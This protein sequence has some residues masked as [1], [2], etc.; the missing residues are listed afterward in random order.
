[1]QLFLGLLAVLLSG[2]TRA[3]RTI[4]V[5]TG[6][7]VTLSC[8][9]T[10]Y[11]WPLWDGPRIPRMNED[12]LVTYS[13][14]FFINPNLP[15]AHKLK[16]TENISTGKYDLQISNASLNEEG[17]YRC[18]DLT[19]WKLPKENYVQLKIKVP[20]RNISINDA[21]TGVLHGTEN[22]F[23]VLRCSVNSGVPKETIMWFNNSLLLGIGGPGTFELN[24]IPQKY[25]HGRFYTCII[26]SSALINF[27][28]QTVKLDIKYK[29]YVTVRK[30]KDY[31]RI[32][33]A[34]NLSVSCLVDSNPVITRIFWERNSTV[35]HVSTGKSTLSL[36]L[37]NV[38]RVDSG[39]YVCRAANA[40]GESYDSIE[41]IVQYPP[42]IE[43]KIDMDK[44]VL[45]CNPNG[46]PQ[47]YTFYPWIHQSEF[48]DIIRCLKNT[49]TINLQ[50]SDDTLN[51]YQ[52]NGIYIC[53]AGNGVANTNATEIQSGQ[54]FVRQN[55][56]PVFVSQNEHRQYG[57]PG[58]K[59]D[60]SVF[61]YSYPKFNNLK[62]TTRGLFSIE[63]NYIDIENATVIDRFHSND[64]RM[65]GFKITLQGFIIEANDF[66]SYKFWI[67]NSVGN[68]NFTVDLIDAE[69]QSGRPL[70]IYWQIA[71]SFIGVLLLGIACTIFRGF[72]HKQ[73]RKHARRQVHQEV[74]Y[75][76][77]E[78]ADNNPASQTQRNNHPVDTDSVIVQEP[79][80]RNSASENPGE[81]YNSE[82]N[83]SRSVSVARELHDYENSYQPLDLDNSE[84]HLYDETQVL[85]SNDIVSTESTYVN[86][87]L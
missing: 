80:S 36:N 3:N 84:K 48:G 41:I 76:E 69:K 22:H 9:V 29:P 82:E 85:C 8:N 73:R 70:N 40:I 87:V 38:S 62:V 74:H 14:R 77:I 63:Y 53:R 39:T 42:S 57:I 50:V 13:D 15:N 30:A 60:L 54:A 72:Y 75:D 1:M 11:D 58:T 17:L 47:N 52:Y 44:K 83:S 18:S 78:L 45:Q 10:P 67:T 27:L 64:F 66:T 21:D 81:A 31:I 37:F 61:V 79:E 35:Y 28:Q 6:D 55:D 86:T 65:N 5:G 19:T 16:I 71:S 26:N 34:Q 59:I 68:A 43:I 20:P 2:F 51:V 4:Y 56:K 32:N 33:K 25:D 46:E 23:L 7:S 12:S 24:I 49:E